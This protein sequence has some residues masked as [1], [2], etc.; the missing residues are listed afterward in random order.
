MINLILVIKLNKKVMA[1]NKCKKSAKSVVK[2]LKNI[3]KGKKPNGEPKTPCQTKRDKEQDWL[4]DSGE[5][6]RLKSLAKPNLT[7]NLL[8]LF[9]AWI[10]L[11]VGYITIVRFIIWLF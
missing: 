5:G 9:F 2:Q 7:E 8:L 4:K 10:P 6:K 11:M 3:I 1:C